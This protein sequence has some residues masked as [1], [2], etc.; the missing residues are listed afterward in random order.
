MT[1]GKFIVFEGIDG[2][3][4]STQSKALNRNLREG[5]SPSIH[6]WEPSDRPV[7][8]LIRQMLS[9]E[10]TSSGD[11][12]HD[13]HL[14]AL[15]FA[16]DRQDHLWHQEG[17]IQRTLA[18]GTHVVCARYVLSS[19]AYEGEGSDELAFVESLNASFPLPDLTVYLDCPVEVALHR[20]TSTRDQIDVFE[21]EEKL[22]RVRSNYETLLRGYPGPVLKLDA[23]RPPD[24]LSRLIMAAISD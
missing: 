5:G 21:N 22:N 18:Q 10:I 15:L 13:R 24:E 11:H 7:G 3:G 4:T 17:G 8:Q 1:K 9:G 19:L 16:A 2:S 6:T 23:T 20:I 14:F 12:K